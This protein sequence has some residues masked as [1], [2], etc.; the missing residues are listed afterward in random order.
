MDY[1]RRQLLRLTGVLALAPMIP[2]WAWATPPDLV[3]R[4]M[5]TTYRIRIAD[6]IPRSSL[7]RIRRSIENTLTELEQRLSLYRPHSEL[8]RLNRRTEKTP[9]PVNSD[10]M[11][12]LRS[13]LHI[14]ATSG[15]AF[16]PFTASLGEQWGFGPQGRAGLRPPV[17][18][19]SVNPDP[20]LELSGDTIRM[21]SPGVGLDLNGIA[22]GDAVDR[23]MD[24]LARH[25][26]HNC[27]VEIGGEIA[28]S[29]M[30]EGNAWRVGIQGPE[31]DLVS[32]ITLDGASVATSGDHVHF[33]MLNGRRY[34]HLM[35]PSTGRPV[36]HDLA[37]VS[38]VAANTRIADAWSTALMVLGPEAG[39]A[40]ATQLQLAALF[41]QRKPGGWA[42]SRTPTYHLLEE[43][44]T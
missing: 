37:L 11:A 18:I 10:T 8:S 1:D 6:D 38:V 4:T 21:L 42:I 44:Q 26:I 16:S 25:G 12:L 39:Y 3:G 33:Y 28:C 40:M 5:G 30:L 23:V 22:K 7:P 27:L 24:R 34:S 29:G 41:I 13:A 35:D 15:G 31:G 20:S 36:D 43:R 9:L 32:H 19:R 2:R 14:K 17:D